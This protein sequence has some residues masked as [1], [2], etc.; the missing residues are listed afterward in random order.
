M[1]VQKYAELNKDGSTDLIDKY[2]NTKTLK[3]LKGIG[4]FFGMDYISIDSLRP[5]EYYSRYD[6]SKNVAYTAWKL[7]ED[8]KVSLAG[9]FHDVGTLSFAHVNSF[10]KGDALTQSDDELSVKSVLSKDEEILEYLYEDG[11]S[12]ESVC[13]KEDYPLIDKEIPALCLDRV[14]GILTASVLLSKTHTFPEIQKLYY[15]LTYFNSLNG[16]NFD[17][18]NERLRDFSGE[19][20]LSETRDSDYED[21]FECIRSYSR[22]LLT[23]EDRY[24]ME[25]LGLA[26]KYYEDIGLVTEDD[27]FNLSEREIIEKILSSD[28]KDVLED[29]LSIKKVDYSISD[30]GL[31]IVSKPK[32]R[33]A[34]PLCLGQMEVCEISDISGTF[35]RELLDIEDDI[36]LTDKRVVGDLNKN[37]VRTLKRYMKG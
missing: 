12:L 35:Y 7:S 26:L 33:Q 6:H 36:K 8:L 20:V 14:D 34:N 9:L 25:V 13:T 4:M 3:R 15:M 18:N 29:I 28:K 30:E 27:L 32:I 21:F 5:S 17:L 10:K 16:M 23:K 37:T 19:I 1:F 2:L 31:I 11:I 22:V 24:M